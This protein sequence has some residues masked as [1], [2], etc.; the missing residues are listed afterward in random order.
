METVTTIARAAA[1]T[2]PAVRAFAPSIPV[3]GMAACRVPACHPIV[4]QSRRA[5]YWD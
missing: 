3:L 2:I 4:Q 5:Q 1:P